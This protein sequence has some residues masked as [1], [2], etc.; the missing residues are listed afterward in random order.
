M[1]TA[2]DKLKE[3]LQKKDKAIKDLESKIQSLESEVRLYQS[4]LESLCAQRFGVREAL[5]AVTPKAE[6]PAV[7]IQRPKYAGMGLTEAI[8]ELFKADGAPP[9]LTPREISEKLQAGGFVSNAKDFYT[10]VYG[11]CVGLQKQGRLRESSKEG[12][13]AYT[14]APTATPR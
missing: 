13:R 6:V 1:E 8:L 7:A 3:V 2:I 5:A 14:Q 10:S 11:V 9:G 12:K 4:D